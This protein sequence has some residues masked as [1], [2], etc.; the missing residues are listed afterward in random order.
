MD[1]MPDKGMTAP[2]LCANAVFNQ[3]LV[4]LFKLISSTFIQQPARTT[5]QNTC[6]LKKNKKKLLHQFDNT[7]PAYTDKYTGMYTLQRNKMF[8]EDTGAEHGRD[9]LFIAMVCVFGCVVCFFKLI[10][11]IS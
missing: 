3:G 6:K 9:I 2:P 4:P 10:K 5:F 7:C 1:F 8:P 11:I